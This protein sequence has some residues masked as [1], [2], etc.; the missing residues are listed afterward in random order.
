MTRR[1]GL[2]TG[3]MIVGLAF[4]A[5]GTYVFATASGMPM[6]VPSLPGPGGLP[7][8]IGILLVVAGVLLVVSSRRRR[9]AGG[10]GGEEPSIEFSHWVEFGHWNVLIGIGCLFL[11]VFLFEIAG[12]PAV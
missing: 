10:A 4:I 5:L 3:E 12:A 7:S 8:V 11:A 6:G 9:A 2:A 1:I